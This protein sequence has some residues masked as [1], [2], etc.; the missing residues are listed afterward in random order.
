MSD[1]QDSQ[2]PLQSVSQSIAIS[3]PLPSSAEFAGYERA[4]PGTAERILSMA[5]KEA[6]HRQEMEKEVVQDSFKLNSRGQMLGF[7]VAIL[8]IGAVFV[9]L[10]L[11]HPLGA[12]APAIVALTGLAAVFAGKNH[13]R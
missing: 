6:A 9:S 3:G 7:S 5:E 2:V 11:D 12:I 10:F 1:K 13:Q 8:S 4:L